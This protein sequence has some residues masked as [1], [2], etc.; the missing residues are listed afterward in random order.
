L[1]LAITSCQEASAPSAETAVLAPQAIS[2]LGDSLYATPPSAALQERYEARRADY[3]LDSTDLDNLIW[4]G[5]F[6]A[7]L[8]DYREAIAIYSRGLERWPDESRLYRHRGHRYL[9]TRQ[10]DRAVADLERAAA[11]IAG[12][13]NSMEPD[14]M[15]NARNI[16]VSSRHGNIWYHLGL[17]YYLQGDLEN[18]RRAYA[19]CLAATNNDDNIVSTTHWLYMINR[20]LGDTT[21]AEAALAVIEPDLDV[22][23]NADYHRACLFYKGLLPEA[24]LLQPGESPAASD[25]VRYAVANWYFYNGDR[26]AAETRLRDILATGAWNSFGYIAAEADLAREFGAG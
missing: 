25:A 10:L 14:G 1:G 12:T 9:S 8:G 11:L 4:Y 3:L 21:A 22:I 6:T 18:A 15:P 2:L 26:A 24:E 23:E 16:P 13:D 7:Y 17:A 19:Q 5:R 20:R